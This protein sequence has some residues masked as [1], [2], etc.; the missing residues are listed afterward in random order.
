MV[1]RAR[2]CLDVGFVYLYGTFHDFDGISLG[3]QRSE[4]VQ[5]I[6]S[7]IAAW[8]DATQ[9]STSVTSGLSSMT[10]VVTSLNAGYVWMLANCLVSAAYV[11]TLTSRRG[12]VLIPFFGRFWQC[13]R[14]SK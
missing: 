7:L 11:R 3:A 8:S 5:V 14:K 13:A 2:H 10:T 4:P 1:W 9:A 12:M 6:S